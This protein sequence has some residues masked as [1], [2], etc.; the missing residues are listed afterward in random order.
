MRQGWVLYEL[1]LLLPLK[2]MVC[3]ELSEFVTLIYSL[4]IYIHLL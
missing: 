3:M 1:C 4:D 2:R